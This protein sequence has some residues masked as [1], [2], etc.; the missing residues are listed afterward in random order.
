MT[1]F[2]KIKTK[3]KF[4]L[5]SFLIKLS[6]Y[7]KSPKLTSLIFAMIAQKINTQGDFTVLCLGRSIFSDDIKAMATFG[8]QIQYRVIH[9]DYWQIIFDYLTEESE[10]KDLT[11]DNYHSD[12][13]LVKGK[14]DYYC[15]LQKMFHLLKKLIGFD[16]VLSG[17]IGYI[18]QQELAKVCEETKVPFVVLHKE[19]IVVS[20]AYKNFLEHYKTRKFVGAKVLFYNEQCM[21]GFLDLKIPGLTKDKAFFVGIPRFD[22]YFSKKSF[23]IFGL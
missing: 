7:I 2:R 9:L 22:C 6:L 23:L 4:Y 10:R 20:D 15:Y 16:A 8:K 17:N 13:I 1:L 3:V 18:V 11:E 5:T 14:Q 12:N 19:A 21:E